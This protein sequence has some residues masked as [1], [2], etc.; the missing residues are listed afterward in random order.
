MRKV[1]SIE[2]QRRKGR[3]NVFLDGEFAFGLRLDVARRSGLRPGESLSDSQIE[4]LERADRFH[5]CHD[6]SLRY[7]G[8]RPRSEGE[9]RERLRRRGFGDEDIEGVITKLKRDGLVDDASFA[10]FWSDNRAQFS[11]RG[12]FML[13]TELRGKG[14]DPRII[15]EVTGDI[16]EEEG[17]YRAARRK[18]TVLREREYHVFRR[19]LGDFLRRRGFGYEVINQTIERVWR[20]DHSP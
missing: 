2:P 10:R 7:L 1:T 19:R 8:Y 18:A 11:P 3:V 6:A 13:K 16:D 9:L 12:R 4:E 5:Q 17:A 20:E 14:V 15:E